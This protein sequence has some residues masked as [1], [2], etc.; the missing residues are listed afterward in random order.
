MLRDLLQ[1]EWMKGQAYRVRDELGRA[2]NTPLV[3]VVEARPF[4]GVEISQTLPA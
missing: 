2:S 4:L 1:T 3:Q